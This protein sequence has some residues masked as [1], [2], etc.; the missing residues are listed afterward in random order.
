MSPQMR[1][2]AA[3][4]C[5]V[6]V[7]DQITKW[8]ILA[9][10]MNPPRTI[11]VLPFFDIVLVWNRGVSFGMF[12]N[13][14]VP[15]WGLVLLSAAI[16]AVLLFW[17]RRAETRLSVISIGLVIGGAIG[18]VV[19]RF[20]YGAVLDFLDLHVGGYHWPAFNLADSGITVGI[21]LLL[22]ES[23]IPRRAVAK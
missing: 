12:G 4:A 8:L 1:L 16:V 13:G 3:I 6:L 11:G 20:V 9:V 17:L 18:N 21:C 22:A 15:P 14:V 19:D 2:G 23:L 7:L 10:V 5:T